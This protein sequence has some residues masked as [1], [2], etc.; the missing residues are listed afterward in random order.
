LCS[1]T[2]DIATV[3]V[4]Q[5]G[6]PSVVWTCT[7]DRDVASSLARAYADSVLCVTS[8]SSLGLSSSTVTLAPLVVELLYGSQP[9]FFETVV[10]VLVSL[11]ME[12]VGLRTSGHKSSICKTRQKRQQTQHLYAKRRLQARKI[13]RMIDDKLKIDAK[14][15]H[16]YQCTIRS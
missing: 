3:A 8:S 1:T 16:E 10:A 4:E 7:G 12:V 14:T 6:V 2:T 5:A 13:R 11:D 9:K 15:R